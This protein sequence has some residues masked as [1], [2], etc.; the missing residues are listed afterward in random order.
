MNKT[1]PNSKIKKIAI[2]LHNYAY[3][4]SPSELSNLDKRFIGRTKLIERL[5]SLITRSETKSGVY[6]ITGYR[7]MGKSSFVSKAIDGISAGHKS[8][9]LVERFFRIL[10]F[11]FFMSIGIE[12]I[13]G[14]AL[15]FVIMGIAIILLILT[16]SEQL[17][18][19]YEFFPKIEI[20]SKHKKKSKY[21]KIIEDLLIVLI[22]YFISLLFAFGRPN[23]IQSTNHFGMLVFEISILILTS[24]YLFKNNYENNKKVI[25][26]R[27]FKKSI[28]EKI[29]NYFSNTQRITLQ[30]NLGFEDLKEID[31]L[32]LV[33]DHL[34]EDYINF[35]QFTRRNWVIKSIF[36]C[37]VIMVTSILFNSELS[38]LND[39]NNKHYLLWYFLPS[40]S[41][42]YLLKSDGSHSYNDK[43]HRFFTDVNTTDASFE[44]TLSK[45]YSGLHYFV[46]TNPPQ[47]ILK[48]GRLIAP[49]TRYLDQV[50]FEIYVTIMNN[51]PF[52]SK[53]TSKIH[54][55]YLAMIYFL[56]LLY[57]TKNIHKLNITKIITHREIYK[58]ISELKEQIEAQITLERG[59]ET[60]LNPKVG[61]FKRSGK[62]TKNYP[63][64][65][66]KE[67][68]G[69]LSG[70]LKKMDSL[71]RHTIRPEYI[72][73]FDELDKLESKYSS[74]QETEVK[75]IDD[76]YYITDTAYRRQQAVI[77]LLSNL[78]EFFTSSKAKF[79]FIAGPELHDAS[80]A[81]I[82]DRDFYIGSIFNSDLYVDSFLKDFSKNDPFDI[83]LTEEYV[84]SNLFPD[85]YI[86]RWKKLKENESKS[87]VYSIKEY[88]NYLKYI[89][90]PNEN[91]IREKIISE[92]LNFVTYLTYRSNG[93]PKKITTYFEQ[94]TVEY[95]EDFESDDYVFVHL[96][97][98][99][100][101]QSEN[102]YLVFNYYHQYTFGMIAYISNPFFYSINRSLKDYS[103]KQLVSIA[104]ILDHIYKFH[105]LAFGWEDIE[106][107]PEIIDI[108]KAT[109]VR[110]LFSTIL[111]FL[112][113]M[114]IEVIDSGLFNFKFN[115]R[116][117][118][119]INFL[120][121]INDQESAA[122]NFTLGESLM[123][124]RHYKNQLNQLSKKYAEVNKKDSPEFIRSLSYLHVILA[125]LHFYDEEYDNAIIEY[126]EAVQLFGDK[127][128]ESISIE[129]ML[130]LIKYNLKLGL[131]YEKRKSYDMAYITYGK[132]VARV[133]GIKD[134]AKNELKK[135]NSKYTLEN[136][137]VLLEKWDSTKDR[138]AFNLSLYEK[139][140]V[141]YL[142]LLSRFQ[143]LE[144]ATTV[145]I[146]S[147]DVSVITEE[148]KILYSEII[149][150][151][152]SII[153]IEFF[154]K[155]GDILYFKNSF[156]KPSRINNDQIPYCTDDKKCLCSANPEL[157]NLNLQGYTLPCSSCAMYMK[158][159]KK[160]LNVYAN[161]KN[162]I[163]T[164]KDFAF[165]FDF[166]HRSNCNYHNESLLRTVA[167][168]FSDVGN[169]FLSCT[170][171]SIELNSS[172]IDGFLEL[173]NRDQDSSN[174]KNVQITEK[175]N[176]AVESLT[177]EFSAFCKN[178]NNR[179]TKIEEVILYYFLAGTYYRKVLDYKE[180]GFQL[181]KILYVLNIH[182]KHVDSI[183][184]NNAKI[185]EDRQK[186]I[187]DGISRRAIKAFY[188]A[189][190]NSHH[191]EL[192]E[193]YL[194]LNDNNSGKLTDLNSISIIWEIQ[195]IILLTSYLNL[196][197]IKDQSEKK[198]KFIKSEKLKS[199]RSL[200]PIY[201][202][203]NRSLELEYFEFIN[204]FMYSSNELDMISKN[205]LI[206]DSIFCLLQ[207]IKICKISGF[208]FDLNHLFAANAYNKLARWSQ[209]MED[210]KIEELVKNSLGYDTYINLSVNYNYELAL[211]HYRLS[212]D[213]HQNGI[214]Y[215]ELI[216]G[217]NYLN[218]D[219]NDNF[220]HFAAAMERF[221]MKA[222]DIIG[223]IKK[224]RNEISKKT[225]KHMEYEVSSYP[226]S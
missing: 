1:R 189:Y 222:S 158:A 63:I 98:M 131:A 198:S 193:Y 205:N 201:S 137:F 88:N 90:Y 125:D 47:Y 150:K 197:F 75:F 127:K 107:S 111:R 115:K 105:K 8:I 51:I 136:H 223:T 165:F 50:V 74:L 59:T 66:L 33:V 93:T 64:L 182:Y 162:K 146:T 192:E 29:E 56:I 53:W 199:L 194:I 178:Y 190:E 97:E 218:D 179:L 37:F 144:K 61:I 27:T 85:S 138:I 216:D 84:C 87:F 108:H 23:F 26:R 202:M 82:S 95:R 31:I 99:S 169:V 70:I 42:E 120:C 122:F 132:I 94:F 39:Y 116:M 185:T 28:L 80:L 79:I 86:Q 172:F 32:K 48:F 20:T 147:A 134:V 102:I 220:Y 196:Y 76:V 91:V 77:K 173:L 224:I 9:E 151:N 148:F 18:L 130:W 101:E 152:N 4:H 167:N 203:Y 124:K 219:Y 153:E 119:E 106:S 7:G 113:Y 12:A 24:Y 140:R 200:K 71:P 81:A 206:I 225:G 96:N 52:F 60:E 38:K 92:L 104:F 17:R 183:K 49:I 168:L 46:I 68:E 34:K 145:G 156:L 41:P 25:N 159:L 109:Q 164:G 43:I 45:K 22:T 149:D 187:T 112:S 13:R 128:F 10:F 209:R 36:I 161:H 211:R 170:S 16:I 2:E 175:Q 6:L 54:F 208:S 155:V 176:K 210:E 57:F 135:S 184:Y 89:I 30:I 166:L 118:D 171:P 157:D 62:K 21:K 160:F 55:N 3:F 217:M 117:T 129:E 5:R 67:I 65:E 188:R 19:N 114:Q 100:N 73:M 83:G 110:E 204:E 139:L 15:Y 177:E 195:E 78:K 58:N 11:L 215:K 143:I 103:D 72:F 226:I 154:D 186:K 123:V 180:Y 163:Q 181:T 40:Q 44:T 69:R 35:V 191:I 207:I 126:L 213:A 214:T 14:T 133:M 221:E 174:E 212:I 121:R 141:M 142:P